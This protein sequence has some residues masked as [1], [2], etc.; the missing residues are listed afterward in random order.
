M[1]EDG[2]V[3][4]L[5]G[6]VRRGGR[7][8]IDHR[9]GT[10]FDFSASGYYTQSIADDP[11]GGRNAFSALSLYPIDV[12]LTE[13]N[14]DPRD[15]NDFLIQ[16]DPGIVPENPLYSARNNDIT[17]TRGRILDAV[18]VFPRQHAITVDS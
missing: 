5:D 15:E 13:L 6:Y 11:Q 7:V 4:G 17:R 18:L 10:T 14:P 8:N 9:I 12:D 1:N 16:P 2:V 3:Q